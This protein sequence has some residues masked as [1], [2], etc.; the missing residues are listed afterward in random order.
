MAA[1]RVNTVRLAMGLVVVSLL[2]T[3]S[4]AAEPPKFERIVH[5]D[6]VALDQPLVFNRL[7]STSPD[8]MIYALARDVVSKDGP[9]KP[10]QKGNVMLRAEKR[11]RPLVLRVNEGDCLEIRFTN[12]LADS[13][14]T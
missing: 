7:G 10:L 5:A 2:R 8:G 9:G 11:P 13:G 1:L 14:G 6:V 12:L 4:A 3:T